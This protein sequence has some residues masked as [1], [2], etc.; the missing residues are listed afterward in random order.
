MASVDAR[1]SGLRQTRRLVRRVLFFVALI[2]Y[3][4]AVLLPIYYIFL[5]AFVSGSRLFSTP[6]DYFPEGMTLDRFRTIFE[7]LPIS[8]YLFNTIF[9]STVSTL[10]A[11]LLSFLAAYAIARLDFPGATLILLGLLASSMLPP[12]ATVIPLF[13]MFT[14]LHLIDTLHGLLLLYVSALLPITVWVLVSFIRQIP[15]EIEDAARVDGANFL[16]VL[17]YIVLP[18]AL[19]G[20]ATM[21]VI[22]FILSWN[23]FFIPLIFARGPDSKVISMALTEAQAN[24]GNMAAVAILATIPVFVITLLFQKQIVSGITCGAVK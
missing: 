14:Q 5:T 6:L 7:S 16:A 17:W 2:V 15:R 13:Q 10:I 8:R 1:A 3:L 22:N 19:P 20:M 11:L 9:L 18:L 23:E 4:I 24:W 21:F 12:A